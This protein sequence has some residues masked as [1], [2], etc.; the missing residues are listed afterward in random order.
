MEKILGS[1]EARQGNLWTSDVQYQL[2][3]SPDRAIAVRIGGQ[4]AGQSRQLLAH[5]LGVI[6]IL[7]HKWFLEKREARRKAEQAKALELC[8]MN[9][10]LAR[11][12]KN[13]ELP[14]HAIKR[15]RIDRK[16]FSMYGPIVARLVFEPQSAR[17]VTLL[18][19]NAPQLDSCRAL[20]ARVLDG[21]L[22]LDPKLPAHASQP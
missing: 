5:Q 13:F 14:F 21:R 3:V 9:E 1:F 20:L 18:L 22:A 10:L 6:G 8:T 12:P 19:Q 2:F 16:R 4:F 15:A 11:H 17:P 7:I